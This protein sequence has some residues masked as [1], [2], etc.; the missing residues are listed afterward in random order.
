MSPLDM[1]G[2]DDFEKLLEKGFGIIYDEYI[3]GLATLD[4]KISWDEQL[5]GRVFLNKSGALKEVDKEE[6]FFHTAKLLLKYYNPDIDKEEK[7]A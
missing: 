6:F 4:F 2:R 3:D 5:K 7:S 1:P